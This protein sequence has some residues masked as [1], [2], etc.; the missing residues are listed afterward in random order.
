VKSRGEQRVSKKKPTNRNTRTEEKRL[1]GGGRENSPRVLELLWSPAPSNRQV[2]LPF[3]LRFCTFVV[4][5]EEHGAKV[6]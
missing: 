4:V 2:R 3:Y 1:R 5:G 6:I